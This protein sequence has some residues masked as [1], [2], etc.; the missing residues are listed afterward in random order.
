VV[1]EPG[2]TLVRTELR[3]IYYLRSLIES[4]QTEK[5]CLMGQVEW[6]LAVVCLF[7][8]VTGGRGWTYACVWSL[9]SSGVVD[10][11]VGV[12]CEHYPN[13]GNNTLTHVHTDNTHIHRWGT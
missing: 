9:L 6:P 3:G 5:F 10:S 12:A 13:L 4:Y 8:W 1:G 2:L 7:S 11:S